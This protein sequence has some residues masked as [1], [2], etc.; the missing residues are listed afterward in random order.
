M[1][2]TSCSDIDRRLARVGGQIEGIR[3]MVAGDRPCVDVLDQIAAAR[4]ALDAVAARLVVD[5]V[6]R[7]SPAVAADELCRAVNRLARR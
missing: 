2:S 3:G 4:A 6:R 7:S 1:T 5:E